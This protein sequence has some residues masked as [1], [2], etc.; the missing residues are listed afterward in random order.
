MEKLT[1]INYN[2]AVH[3]KGTGQVLDVFQEGDHTVVL[4]EPLYNE[5]ARRGRIVTKP[6][7]A[8]DLNEVTVSKG[9][10]VN[11]RMRFR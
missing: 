8:L 2:S 7:I 10:D 6:V 5:H 4:C 3:G 11:E 1:Y 9:T